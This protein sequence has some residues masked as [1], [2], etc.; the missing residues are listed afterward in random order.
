MEWEY[1][2]ERGRVEEGKVENTGETAKIKDHLKDI[3][4]T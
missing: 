4:K 1:Q 2:V 3:I